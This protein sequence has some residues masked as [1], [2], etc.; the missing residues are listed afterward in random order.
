[1]TFKSGITLV[2]V[3]GLLAAG[4][5]GGGKEESTAGPAQAKQADAP[6]K[7]NARTA[8][9]EMEACFV[10]ATSY[11]GCKPSTAGGQV[12]GV[13]DATYTLS[14]KSTSGNTFV[15]AKTGTGLTR[16]CTTAG[17]GG[18]SAGGTW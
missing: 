11:A 15:I 16:S 13:T 5:G 14:A 1:M 6:A 8:T 2:V 17:Q 10:D 7:S 4:C 12:S 9:S 3:T 18:C